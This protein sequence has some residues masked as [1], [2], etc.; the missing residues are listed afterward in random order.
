MREKSPAP[1]SRTF[2]GAPY[3]YG[4]ASNIGYGIN[5]LFNDR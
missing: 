2:V 3:K 5:G 4:P 1:R